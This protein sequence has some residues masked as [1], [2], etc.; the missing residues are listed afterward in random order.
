MSLFDL[1]RHGIIKRWLL[2]WQLVFSR[3]VRRLISAAIIQI[4]LYYCYSAI[5]TSIKIS[6]SLVSMYKCCIC[7]SVLNQEH[8]LFDP[9]IKSRCHLLKWKSDLCK[10]QQATEY[11]MFV[12]RERNKALAMQN[13]CWLCS[14]H[15]KSG[16]KKD[17]SFCSKC[18]SSFYIMI[19]MHMAWTITTCNEKTLVDCY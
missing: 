14:R 19:L 12:K 8:P 16:G 13:S 15:A 6:G 1:V 17:W 18:I 7:M 10:H 3:L 4:Q 9:L 2:C 5:L 11:W